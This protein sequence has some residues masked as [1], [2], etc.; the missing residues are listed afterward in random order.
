MGRWVAGS[1]CVCVW[2]LLPRFGGGALSSNVFTIWCRILISRPPRVF[3]QFKCCSCQC[4]H[5][6]SVNQRSDR[7]IKY[8]I[9]KRFHSMVT[10]DIHWSRNIIDKIFITGWCCHWWK[11]HQSENPDSKVHGAHLGPTGPRWA[12]CWRHESCYL[13]TFPSHCD[14]DNYSQ[15]H[16]SRPGVY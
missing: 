16:C 5:K 1:V 9:L 6:L 4:V 10:L 15:W 11:S 3:R 2:E 8:I 7:P 12:P 14:G 13:G